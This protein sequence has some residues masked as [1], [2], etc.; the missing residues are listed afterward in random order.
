MFGK[1]KG[2][3]EAPQINKE[4]N[5]LEKAVKMLAEDERVRELVNR[6]QELQIDLTT[7]DA[8]L[9]TEVAMELRRIFSSKGI[10]LGLDTDNDADIRTFIEKFDQN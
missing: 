2:F 9:L 3:E 5:S 8:P 4:V 10:N 7:A 1:R 6:Y